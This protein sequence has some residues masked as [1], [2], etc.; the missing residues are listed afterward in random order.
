MTFADEESMTRCMDQRPH[1]VD[2]REVEAKLAVPREESSGGGGGGSNSSAPPSQQQG[3]R[4][5]KVCLLHP[6]V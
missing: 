2:G 3:L 4:T 1:N 5:K 6:L